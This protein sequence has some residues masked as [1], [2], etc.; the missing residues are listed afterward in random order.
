MWYVYAG[1]PLVLWG[2]LW[3]VRRYFIGQQWPRRLQYLDILV[4]VWWYS[5]YYLWGYAQGYSIVLWFLLAWW[6]IG[7]GLAWWLLMQHMWRPVTFWRRYWQW[8]GYI[9]LI[10]WLI[11]IILNMILG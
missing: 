10:L 6:G 9:G 5:A 7:I 2:V 8:S 3:L 11:G 4:P 1:L